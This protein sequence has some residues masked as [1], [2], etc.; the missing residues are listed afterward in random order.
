MTL[1]QIGLIVFLVIIIIVVVAV[2]LFSMGSSSSAPPPPAVPQYNSPVTGAPPYI[3]PQNSGAPP[4]PIY[5][6]PYPSPV[7]PTT[8]SPPLPSGTQYTLPT[9]PPP[10]YRPPPPPPTPAPPAQKPTLYRAASYQADAWQVP[11]IGRF[12]VA[13]SRVR[14]EASSIRVP[15]GW[16]LTVYDKDDCSG[17]SA[18]FTSDVD[19]LGGTGLNNDIACVDLQLA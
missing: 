8:V 17:K 15:T 4:Q 14:N 5:V 11:G 1:L 16:K 18:V 19:D 12:A 2:V 9:P 6:D 13:N 10:V 7:S 3:P